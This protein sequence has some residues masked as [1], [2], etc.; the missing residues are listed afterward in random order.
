[1]TH[2]LQLLRHDAPIQVYTWRICC[3]YSDTTHQILR[4]NAST[5]TW[6]IHCKYQ[7]IWCMSSD[8]CSGWHASYVLYNLLQKTKRID[9]D[10]THPNHMMHVIRILR[11]IWYMSSKYQDMMHLLRIF[12]HDAS[13]YT[14]RIYSDIYMTHLLQ[15]LRHD[16]STYTWRICCKY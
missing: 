11:H 9:R 12:R 4:H 1:M 13:K 8:I 7:D 2:L 6:H 15:I 14:R 3:E 5:E 10:M 16:V